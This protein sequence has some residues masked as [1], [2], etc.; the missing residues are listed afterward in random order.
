MIDD[1]WLEQSMEQVGRFFEL[2]R[3]HRLGWWGNADTL[4]QVEARLCAA[5]LPLVAMNVTS[6]GRSC[7][8]VAIFVAAAVRLLT[9]GR[10]M[11]SHVLEGLLESRSRGEVMEALFLCSDRAVSLPLVFWYHSYPELRAPI[12]QLWT[13]MGRPVEDELIRMALAATADPR[14]QLAALAYLATRGRGGVM[15]CRGIYA[16]PDWLDVLQPTVAAEACRAGLLC[17]DAHAA[18]QALRGV[19]H[20]DAHQRQDFLQV[21]VLADHHATLPLVCEHGRSHPLD[22][23]WLLALHGSR[24]ALLC[25]PEVLARCSLEDAD[26]TAFLCMGKPLPRL[27]V[28]DIASYDTMLDGCMLKARIQQQ[29][30]LD[31]ADYWL[32]GKPGSDQ[33][34]GR[35]ASRTVGK[36][37]QLLSERLALRLGNPCQVTPMDWMVRRDR[38]VAATAYKQLLLKAAGNSG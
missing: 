29:L 38:R 34:L 11:V 31:R 3:A 7:P 37:G 27:P 25:L 16:Q 20:V 35:M 17:G 33:L 9:G 21:L 26:P 19:R 8:P 36:A 23:A 13:T 28:P 6:A 14:Q 12:M 30:A 32:M 22:A 24:K 5:L 1:A 18:D 2:R 4:R 10:E 15:Q